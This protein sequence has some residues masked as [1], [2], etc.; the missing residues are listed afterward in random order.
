MKKESKIQVEETKTFKCK[1]TSPNQ[2]IEPPD[3][4]VCSH[5][6]ILMNVYL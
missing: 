5:L 2:F 6:G 1:T 3:Y 4:T